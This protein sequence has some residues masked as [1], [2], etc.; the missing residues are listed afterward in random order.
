[1]GPEEYYSF[2]RLEREEES[3]EGR[4]FCM[5]KGTGP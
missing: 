2:G 3:I 4:S 1:M 5:S